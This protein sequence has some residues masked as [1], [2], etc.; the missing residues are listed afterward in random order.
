VAVSA[1]KQRATVRG[2]A[3]TVSAGRD[4]IACTEDEPWP[5]DEGIACRCLIVPDVPCAPHRVKADDPGWCYEC[6]S[7]FDETRKRWRKPRILRAAKAA[8]RRE[9][10]AK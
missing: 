2:W 10:E 9:E 5:Q 7:V 6:G 4:T 1:A 8:K 3:W